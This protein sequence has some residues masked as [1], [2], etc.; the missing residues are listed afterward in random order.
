VTYAPPNGK[1]GGAAGYYWEI[2]KAGTL[3]DRYFTAVMGSST[4]NHMYLYAATSG[5]AIDNPAPNGSTM[6]VLTAAGKIVSHPAHFTPAEIPTTLLNEL[7]KKGLSWRVYEES[8]TPNQVAGAQILANVADFDQSIKLIDVA[9]ALPSFQTNYV[10]TPELD[11]KLEQILASGGGANVVWIKPHAFNSEHPGLGGVAQGAEWTR[12]IVN[13]IGESPYWGHCAIFITWDDYG[14]FYD[15]VAPPQVDAFGLGFRV[16][17]IVLSPWAKKGFV[18]HTL[19]EH[20]SLVRF[21]E[22]RFGISPMASRDAAAT[23]MS[24]AFDFSQAP[25]SFSEFRFEH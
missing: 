25:R 19:Y 12:Q 22:D 7:E 13:A 11:Q 6:N 5:G 9:T 10:E 14:G 23:G 24:G 18:D 20:S 3:C 21:A 17:C 2:A 15:H 8:T 4:P 1:T 16:P